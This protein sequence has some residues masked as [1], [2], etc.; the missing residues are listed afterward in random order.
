MF[1]RRMAECKPLAGVYLRS[2]SRY[3]GALVGS[4]AGGSRQ[5]ECA[6]T[7]GL[8][9]G[10]PTLLDTGWRTEA[11]GGFQAVLRSSGHWDAVP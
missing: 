8:E 10:V 11:A 9:G 4:G 1:R 7:E 2:I 5:A 6:R 3:R